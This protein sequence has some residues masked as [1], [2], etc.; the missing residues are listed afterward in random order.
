MVSVMAVVLVVV[1]IV[2]KC[3]Y[4]SVHECDPQALLPY[5]RSDLTA[6]AHQS[7]DE[8]L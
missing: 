5:W 7:T 4:R 3:V 2:C 1:E 6:R 8:S